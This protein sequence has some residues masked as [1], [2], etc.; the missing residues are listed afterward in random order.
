MSHIIPTGHTSQA[1]ANGHGSY[2]NGRHI[3]P[4]CMVTVLIGTE[5]ASVQIGGYRT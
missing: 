4:I 5:P 2:V 3:T 1:W